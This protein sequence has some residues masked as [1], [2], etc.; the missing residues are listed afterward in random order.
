[1]SAM[2]ESVE[3][4]RLDGAGTWEQFAEIQAVYAAAFPDYDLDDH[5]APAGVD[6]P[7]RQLDHLAFLHLT[8]K[9]N[10]LR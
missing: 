9:I 5:R 10:A 8:D 3:T 6:E 7:R 2:N 4:Q 1:M